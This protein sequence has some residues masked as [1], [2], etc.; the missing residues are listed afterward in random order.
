M[1][2]GGER[3]KSWERGMGCWL[4]VAAEEVEVAQGGTHPCLCLGNRMDGVVMK[5]RKRG[6]ADPGV[7]IMDSLFDTS[8]LKCLSD[9][10]METPIDRSE[11]ELENRSGENWP[12][13]NT[14]ASLH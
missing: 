7:Q 14:E 2:G 6:V 4:D 3:Q 8:S 9:I 12:S 10:Q 1:R 11:A 13:V 5:V